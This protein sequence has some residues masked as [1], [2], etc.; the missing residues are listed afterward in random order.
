MISQHELLK[1]I[2]LLAE[3]E[4]TMISQHE[5]LNLIALLAEKESTMISQHELLKLIASLAYQECGATPPAP[6][7]V[8]TAASD[9]TLKRK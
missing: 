9:T 4:S 2:A 1:L 5:L 3:K 6:Y 8:T 7:C